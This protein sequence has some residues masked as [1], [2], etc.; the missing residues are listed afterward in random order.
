MANFTRD[1]RTRCT[2]L[3]VAFF[4]ARSG[5]GFLSADGGWYHDDGLGELQVSAVI[6]SRGQ[7]EEDAFVTHLPQLLVSGVVAVLDRIYAGINRGLY[8]R[9]LNCVVATLRC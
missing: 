3:I 8:A 4:T 1:F 7:I 9:D 6:K 5:A 2:K